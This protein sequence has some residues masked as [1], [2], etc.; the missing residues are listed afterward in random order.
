MSM[1]RPS[2]DVDYD[3]DG[4]RIWQSID[5]ISSREPGHP[6][7]DSISFLSNRIYVFAADSATVQSFLCRWC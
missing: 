1:G 4:S 3:D 2:H 7:T 6:K 5:S